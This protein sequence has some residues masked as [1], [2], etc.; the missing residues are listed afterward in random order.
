VVLLGYG[1][2]ITNVYENTAEAADLE[3]RIQ[4]TMAA[5]CQLAGV[6]PTDSHMVG[7]RSV[8]APLFYAGEVP[9]EV[10]D[11]DTA[12]QSRVPVRAAAEVTTPGMVE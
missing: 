4:Q 9:Q 7:P 10:I 11:A 6:Q 8:L 5:T 3:Q 12:A 2:Q 1:I